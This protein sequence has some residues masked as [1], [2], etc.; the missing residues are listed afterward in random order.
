LLYPEKENDQT[1]ILLFSKQLAGDLIL[2]KP[3]VPAHD[4]KVYRRI[5]NFAS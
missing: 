4:L 5:N 2:E 3:S 1:V